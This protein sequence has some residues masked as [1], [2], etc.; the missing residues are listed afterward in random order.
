MKVQNSDVPE[1]ISIC[2]E[3]KGWSRRVWLSRTSLTNQL[4]LLTASDLM[5][6]MLSAACL[7]G[8]TSKNSLQTRDDSYGLYSL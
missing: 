5:I 7:P 6:V 4:V 1:H 3:S 2:A 8:A